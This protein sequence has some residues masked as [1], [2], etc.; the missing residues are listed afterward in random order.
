MAYQK[1]NTFVFTASRLTSR[2]MMSVSGKVE[3]VSQT[4][5]SIDLTKF[6]PNNYSVPIRPITMDDGMEP[7]GSWKV[8]YAAESKRAN[9]ILLKGILCFTAGCLSVYYGGVFDGVIMPNL[10]NI[11]EETEPWNFEKE[12]RITV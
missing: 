7:Y 6:D 9:M 12:G 1:L 2:R 11:M 3:S 4:K 5:Q 10:D 8:A